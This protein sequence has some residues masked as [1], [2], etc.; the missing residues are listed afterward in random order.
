MREQIVNVSFKSYFSYISTSSSLI[1][2]IEVLLIYAN[3][4][5]IPISDNHATVLKMREMKSIAS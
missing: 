3:V 2:I 1:S 4:Q 5:E